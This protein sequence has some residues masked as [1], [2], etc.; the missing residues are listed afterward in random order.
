MSKILDQVLAGTPP[1]FDDDE[2]LAT[3]EFIQRALGSFRG[4]QVL[5]ANTTMT[6][7]QVGQLIVTASGSFTLTLPACSSLPDGA[8]IIF[9]GSTSSAAIIAAAGT[10]RLQSGSLVIASLT[11]TEGEQLLLIN[12]KTTGRWVAASGS[13]AMLGAAQLRVGGKLLVGTDQSTVKS[14]GTPAAEVSTADAD[15]M[16]FI[17]EN[18]TVSSAVG[19]LLLAGLNSADAV[20][21]YAVVDALLESVTN[22]AERAAI[23][24]RA[25]TGGAMADVLKINGD[26]DVSGSALAGINEARDFTLG[27]KLLTPLGLNNAFTGTNQ[28][29]GANGYQKLPGGLILQ[30]GTG[31]DT[32]SNKSFPIPFPTACYAI[33]ASQRLAAVGD[34]SQPADAGVFIVSNSQ[35]RVTVGDQNGVHQYYW[36][37]IGA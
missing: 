15:V 25:M 16:R 1:Q 7:A 31:T 32:A 5:S 13:A 21:D 17:R 2:S 22:G 28:D 18:K 8:A 11:L 14:G 10:D 26:G 9:M 36:I 37:A 23:R 30:W 12:R 24:L 27:T 20:T 33:V 3:T 6:A 4:V 19:R 35:F 34:T 29:K